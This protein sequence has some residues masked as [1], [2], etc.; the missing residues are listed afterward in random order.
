MFHS[1]YKHIIDRF[2]DSLVKRAYQGLLNYSKNPILLEM[3]SEKSD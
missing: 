2:S 1:D 3:I